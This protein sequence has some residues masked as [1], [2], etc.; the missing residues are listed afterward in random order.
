MNINHKLLLLLVV[1]CQSCTQSIVI[2]TTVPEPL[3]EKIENFNIAV[4]YEDNIQ[5][6]Q[7]ENINSKSSACCEIDFSDSQ[8]NLFRKILQS[9][10]PGLIELP[11]NNSEML[12]NVDLYMEPQLDAFEFLSPEESRNDKYAVW[13]KYK[14]DIYDNKKTLLSNWYITGYGEQNTGS[15]GVSES[16]T[17]AI[18]L[19]LRDTGVNLAIK[20]EDDFDKLVKLISTDL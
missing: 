16:L 14:I 12:S 3:V 7:Y 11:N 6:Y 15:F 20:I 8:L 19:A 4:I 17:K 18:D 2:N 13:L 5:N 10:F 9:F 1:L